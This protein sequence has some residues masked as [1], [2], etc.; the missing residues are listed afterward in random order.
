MKTSL[1]SKENDPISHSLPLNLS[2]KKSTRGN[3]YIGPKILYFLLNMA[4]YSVYHFGPPYLKKVWNIPDAELSFLSILTAFSFIGSILWTSLADRYKFYKSLLIF[5]TIFFAL[6]FTALEFP[7]IKI[8]FMCDDLSD[9]SVKAKFRRTAGVSIFYL[10]TSFF[11][12]GLYPLLDNK[13]FQ[14]LTENGANDKNLYGRQRLWG[15]VGQACIGL[16][17]G[18]MIEYFGFPALFGSLLICSLLFCLFVITFTPS[19]P[20]M[21]KLKNASSKGS[22]KLFFKDIEFLIFLLLVALGG[23]GRAIVGNFLTIYLGEYFKMSNGS[24]GLVLFTRVAP[25]IIFFFLS[26][27]IIRKIGPVRT[28]LLALFTG[29]LRVG[30]YAF[31]PIRVGLGNVSLGVELLKGVNNALLLTA[32]AHLAHDLAPPNC[33]ALAQGVFVGVHGNIA[34]ALAGLTGYIILKIRVDDAYPIRTLFQYTF[35]VSLAGLTLTVLNQF[36]VK[37]TGTKL[38]RIEVT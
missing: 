25:E 14:I 1:E 24:Q 22:W 2:E 17:L 35:Y 20:P 16:I 31:L 9:I 27:S 38:P 7:F 4:V 32:G 36:I 33:G 26:K 5:L 21:A 6:S 34:T 23:F 28:L 37:R 30:I 18:K 12:S 10:L 29:C 19:T 15:A 8:L 3:W 11:I 13:I